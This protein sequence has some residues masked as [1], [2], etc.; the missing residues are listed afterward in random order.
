MHRQTI[1][2]LHGMKQPQR[3][4][5]GSIFSPSCFFITFYRLF[6]HYTMQTQQ[7]EISENKATGQQISII[8]ELS[9]SLI[10]VCVSPIICG[11]NRTRYKG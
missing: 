1:S 8:L 3:S 10:D 11:V 9:G 7:S 5:P 2:V 6:F 4:C